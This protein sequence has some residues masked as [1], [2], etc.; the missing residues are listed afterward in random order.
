MLWAYGPGIGTLLSLRRRL[1]LIEY[2]NRFHGNPPSGVPRQIERD[3]PSQ[4][5]AP[6]C[7]IV[8]FRPPFA[9]RDKILLG[10]NRPHEI[11]IARLFEKLAKQRLLVAIQ[12]SAQ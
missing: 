7:H 6:A 12:E 5:A 11:E 4:Q 8:R 3:C 9:A 2:Q 10:P 1:F